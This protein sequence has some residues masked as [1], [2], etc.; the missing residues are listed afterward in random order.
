[1]HNIAL[2]LFI[3][4]FFIMYFIPTLMAY[5]FKVNNR[6][7]ILIA[8]ILIGWTCIGWFFCLFWFDS[9]DQKQNRF[10]FD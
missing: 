8:N 5:C 9:Q 6:D 3:F 4:V 10:K 7:I 2:S 1:M